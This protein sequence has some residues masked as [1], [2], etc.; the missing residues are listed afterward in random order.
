MS[1]Q[2]L[3]IIVGCEELP[4]RYVQ[5][6]STELKKECPEDFKGHSTW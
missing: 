1:G 2:D 3:L 4:A 5:Y 6:A